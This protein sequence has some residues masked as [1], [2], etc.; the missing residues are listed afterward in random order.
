MVVRMRV[1]RSH[2][3]NRRSHHGLKGPRLSKC[4]NCEAPHLRHRMCPECGNYRGRVVIDV[5]AKL[6]KKLKKREERMGMAPEETQE[7]LTTPKADLG[8][9]V[10]AKTTKGSS[11][12]KKPTAKKKTK[13]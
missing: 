10:N 13:I 8:K 12:E 1:T 3:N 7:D 2:R 9:N 11:S 4:A 5:A 6:E